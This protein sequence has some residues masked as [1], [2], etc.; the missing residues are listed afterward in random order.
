MICSTLRR[1]TSAS[2]AVR[3][4]LAR[5]LSSAAP[6]NFIVT[7]RDDGIT[8]VA[9]NRVEGKNSMS[10]AMIAEFNLLVEELNAD[11]LSRAVILTSAVPKVFCAGAD[12]KERKTMVQYAPVLIESIY[13]LNCIVLHF[14]RLNL[15]CSFL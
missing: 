10:K 12:L 5:P 1:L 3:L 14:I 7:N 11:T 9:M 4:S 13:T 8:I 2:R 6:S 15:M